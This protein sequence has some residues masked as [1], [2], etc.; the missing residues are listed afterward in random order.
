MLFL[1]FIYAA[2]AECPVWSCVED[3]EDPF[4]CA[5]IRGGTILA[6]NAGCPRDFYCRLEEFRKWYGV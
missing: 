5:E 4:I 2:F 1:A 6:N 3:L